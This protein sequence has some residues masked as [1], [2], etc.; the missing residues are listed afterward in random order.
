[1]TMTNGELKAAIRGGRRVYGT[2]IVSP[3]P[4][5]LDRVAGLRLDLVF[6]DTEHIA[7]DRAQLSWMC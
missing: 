7:L 2:L 4:R 3:S 5:W 6:I 1:M